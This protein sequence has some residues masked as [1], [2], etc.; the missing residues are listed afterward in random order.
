MFDSVGN[1]VA[2]GV[3]VNFSVV[4]AGT[5]TPIN[6]VTNNGIAISLIAASSSAGATVVVTA[7]DSGI[8]AP[9]QVSIRIDCSSICPGDADCDGVSDALD[10]CPAAP[11]PDQANTNLFNHLANRPGSDVRGDVCDP[12]I[13]GDGYGN[14]KKLALGKNPLVYCSIMRAD[15]DGDHGV[16]ILDLTRIAQRFA[17]SIP[18]APQRYAQDADNQISILDLT[19]MANVFTQ[20]ISACP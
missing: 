8:A 15:V 19:R 14:T 16:S 7:G 10:N 5:A 12:D 4:A 11:N 17:Q 6:A 1:T 2:N 13:S 9:I 20:Y 18:P 3:P